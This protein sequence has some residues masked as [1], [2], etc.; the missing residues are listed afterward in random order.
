MVD[1][2]DGEYAIWD[3]QTGTYYVDHEGVTEYFDDEWLANDY[4]EEVRQSVAAMEAVQ[5]EESA[6]NIAEPVEETP[7]WNYQVGDTVYLD[8]TAFLV[9]QI[10]DRE[11]QLRDPSL[12]YPIFRA[13]SREN[14]EKMLS[15]D[16]R[17]HAV[18]GDAYTEANSV[19]EEIQGEISTETVQPERRY[20]VAAYHHFENGFDDKLDYY[21]LEEAE[22]AAQGYV[23]GTM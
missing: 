17:N 8:D 19:T 4:L 9:E 13:E 22:K 18:R 15:Q 3:E 12:L 23:D 20:L 21:S 5:P 16:E 6:D 11:V 7:V 1:T 14:F 10:T 2:E